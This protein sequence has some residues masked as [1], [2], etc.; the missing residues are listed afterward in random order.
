MR[1]VVE[2][3]MAKMPGNCHECPLGF[4]GFCDWAPAETEGICPDEGRPEWCPMHC[5]DAARVVQCKDCRYWDDGDSEMGRC[6]CT[7]HAAMT[8]PDWFCWAGYPWEDGD[9]HG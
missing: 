1:L 4:G 9:A 5:Q 8:R 7:V 6:W 2:S 3:N